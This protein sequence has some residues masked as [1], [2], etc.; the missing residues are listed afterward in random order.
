MYYLDNAATTSVATEVIA[1]IQQIM[2]QS[3]GN[4]SSLYRLGLDSELILRKSRATI[5]QTLGCSPAELYFT[6]CGTESNNLAILGAVKARKQWANHIVCTG[7]EHPSVEKPIK[8]LEQEG[9]KISWVMPDSEGRIDPKEIAQQVTAKTALVTAMQVNNE[10]GAILDI[11]SMAKMVKEK[12]S[13][14]MVHIDGV[15]GWLRIPLRLCH[16]EI[17]SYSISGHKI[18]APKGIGAIYIRKNANIQPVFLGGGQERGIR[19]GTENLPY[20]AGLAKA[21]DLMQQN[22]AKRKKQITQCNQQLRNALQQMENVVINSPVD[23][24]PE[25]LNFSILGIRSETMLH[26]LEQDE[27]YVSSG[28]ACSKGIASHTLT[29]MGL[30]TDRIDSALRVSFSQQNSAEDVEILSQTLQRG[31]ETLCKVK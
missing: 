2:Q 17:D 26:F 16:T 20:I 3:F 5:A 9:W 23:A 19:S 27:I 31:I 10:I 4:P 25:I 22:Y 13:R 8:M 14:T 30:A 24:V 28:S 6:S 12:N 18:H 15:Q 21:A 29:N 11:Q 7:Y 1:E